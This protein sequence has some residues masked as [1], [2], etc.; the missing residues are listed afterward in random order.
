M[1]AIPFSLFEK[2]A[3]GDWVI[4]GTF[5]GMCSL[6]LLSFSVP[7]L[8]QPGQKGCNLLEPLERGW[9]TQQIG[10]EEAQ[11]SFLASEQCFTWWKSK[12]W[13]KVREKRGLHFQSFGIPWACHGDLRP[14]P[15]GPQGHLGW[16][17]AKQ[18]TQEKAQG[19]EGAV[20]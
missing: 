18:R 4:F 7:C 14:L 2:P 12:V 6:L 16:L 8:L 17:W 11:I 20:E 19:G 13:M 5:A 9:M 1:A 10:K 3:W 15:Q